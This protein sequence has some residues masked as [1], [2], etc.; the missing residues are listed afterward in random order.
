MRVIAFDLPRFTGNVSK[1]PFF[2]G[3][4]N[5]KKMTLLRH[6]SLRSARSGVKLGQTGSIWA[7]ATRFHSSFA[8]EIVMGRA[9]ILAD[10]HLVLIL[11]AFSTPI[12]L[13]GL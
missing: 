12:T 5:F 9:K 3:V 10:F 13:N 7:R 8:L 2:R 11:G 4:S 6:F 1:S